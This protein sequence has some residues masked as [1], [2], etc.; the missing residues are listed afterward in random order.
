MAGGAVWISS[1]APTVRSELSA[2]LSA[3]PPTAEDDG[4]ELTDDLPH[5]S[6]VVWL[7]LDAELA[8]SAS[9]LAADELVSTLAAAG[10]AEH[11][12][13][14]SS[15]MVYGAWPNNPVPL[16]EEATLRPPVEFGLA[17]R[18]GA[19]EQ[20]VDDWRRAVPGRTVAVLR[21]T[22]TMSA[23]ATSRLAAALAAGMGLRRG[24]DDAPA[25]FVHLDDVLSAL[26]LAVRARLDGVY[27]VAPDGWV[28]GERVRALA[29]AIPKLKLPER[30]REVL[31]T[32]R[33]RFTR[34]P[35]PPGMAD[36]TRWPWLVAND[37]L[38]NAGWQ[39]TVT[40]EQAYV[41]GTEQRWWTMISPKRRQEAAL[42][43]FAIGLA[44]LLV[45]AVRWVRHARSRTARG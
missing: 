1:H 11:L 39:P 41:E 23:R 14:L 31:D 43:L 26:V 6:C 12:V 19:L 44:G 30:W 38:K 35:I 25:Q 9:A 17:R 36:Y 42:G 22:V 27:N 4:R 18:L 45:A 7:A 16:T 2:R 5:A 24:E 3:A 28:S 15:A 29:G 13:V 10:R 20:R 8:P 37:R 34:G 32:L 40:N 33:W 21:P